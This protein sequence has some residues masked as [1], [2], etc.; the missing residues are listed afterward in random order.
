[1][2]LNAR[3]VEPARPKEKPYEMADG[4]GVIIPLNRTIHF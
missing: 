1:M 4:G 2:K 3:Q